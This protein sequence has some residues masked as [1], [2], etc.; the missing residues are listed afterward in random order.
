MAVPDPVAAAADLFLGGEEEERDRLA[1]RLRP[2]ASSRFTSSMA[3]RSSLLPDVDVLS[4]YLATVA[5]PCT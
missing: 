2:R 5:Q 4:R 3:R 1:V